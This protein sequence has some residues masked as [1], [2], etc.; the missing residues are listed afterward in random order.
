[1]TKSAVVFTEFK[2]SAGAGL[3][4]GSQILQQM[5]GLRPHVV[6]V[7][8][9]SQF[10]YTQVLSSLQESCKPDILIGCSS[11][12][13]FT[14]AGSGTGCASAL[15]L[16]ST[17][18]RFS[19][20]LG[21]GISGNVEQCA[22][23]LFSS[24]QGM[25]ENAPNFHYRSAL[26]FADALSGYT[27]ELIDSLTLKTGG[28]Y[29]FFG[30]GAGDD[31][32]FKQ[33]DVFSGTESY[34]DSVVM[35]EILSSK[36]IG[37]GVN[38]GWKPEGNRMRVTAAGGR[39]LISLNAIPIIEVLENYARITLQHFDVRNPLPFFLHNIL[40]IEL[41]GGYKLRVPLEILDDGSLLLAADIPL[42][43]TVSF[44]SADMVSTSNAAV[45]AASAALEQL[46]GNKPNVALFFDCV[47]TRLRMGKDFGFELDELKGTLNALN[48]AGCNTYGQVARV[49][50]QFSGFHNCT[51]VVCI[52]P[53]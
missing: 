11:A 31:A 33:T 21:R 34:T 39:K 9:S 43:A 37:V 6:I 22:V 7:F 2:S 12:G 42:G 23:S 38:H 3:D 25:Q 18:M 15:A 46:Q 48:Y 20:G 47:A 52:I 10:D 29:Q 40:G 5:E 27:D 13:E 51:A 28:T 26:L 24:F 4:M 14:S 44:M 30:G 8:L 16:Y 49:N 45:L 35:L 19:A 53:E 17:E 36:P 1:M 41:A 50:G 32:A